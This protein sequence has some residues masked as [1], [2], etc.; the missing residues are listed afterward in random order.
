LN[1]RRLL[2]FVFLYLAGLAIMG[3]GAYALRFILMH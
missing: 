3:A 1:V 2:W